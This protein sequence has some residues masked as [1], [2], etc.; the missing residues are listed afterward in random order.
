M[1]VGVPKEVAPR[2]KRVAQTPDTVARLTKLGITVNVEAGAG[3]SSKCS[4][5]GYAAV[6]AKIV[7]RDEARQK[8]RTF[9]FFFTIY[10]ILDYTLR[11]GDGIMFIV[12]S[13]FPCFQANQVLK[14]V[15]LFCV[16]NSKDVWNGGS[17]GF[18]SGRM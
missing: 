7:G 3:E 12:C 18:P 5:E 8:K 15:A 14:K 13:V 11:D 16:I 1:S 6:G 4:D 9:F 17:R 10:I 2:E